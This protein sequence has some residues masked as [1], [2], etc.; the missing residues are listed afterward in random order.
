MLGRIPFHLVHLVLI[1]QSFRMLYCH[2]EEC[3][4]QTVSALLSAHSVAC[5]LHLLVHTLVMMTFDLA[6]TIADHKVDPESKSTSCM[7]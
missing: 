5:E 7:H 1:F 2:A 3:S 4:L 6:D